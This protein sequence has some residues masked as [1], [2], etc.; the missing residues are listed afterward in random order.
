[1]KTRDRHGR[2]T[3]SQR[4]A[5]V[6]REVI[7]THV[8]TGLAVGSARLSR[9]ASLAVSP[10]TI[11][12]LMAE[13]EELGL[14]AQPHTSAGRIPTDRAYRLYV[15]EL[16]P[17]PRV[18]AARARDIRDEL[19]R[20]QREAADLLTIAP[21]LLSRFSR[22]A[23]LV[24]A[25]DPR[26][27]IVERF[28]FVRQDE[29]RVLAILIGRAGL[30]EHRV[31]EIDDGSTQ[32]ELDRSA[33][34]LSQEFGGH[35]LRRIRAAVL[36]RLA[37]ERAAYDRL[38]ARSLEL[39]RRT[40]EAEGHAGEVI[41]DGTSNLLDSP[42]FADLARARALLRA[43]E[44][45]ERLIVLLERL[46]E[47]NEVQVVIGEENPMAALAGCSLVTAVYSAAGR[48]MGTIGIV[49]PTRMDYT[50]AIALVSC[51]SESISQLLSANRS[52]PE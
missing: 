2:I 7:R 43:L 10:A 45:K 24:L 42:E 34:L 52:D 50:R 39:G 33:R 28:E 9:R 17:P 18:G 40:V 1:M 8:A 11:R 27:M 25:P 49:G 23:A 38:L 21:R 36:R 22:Q 3:L 35:S 16:M 37:E 15:D 14:L 26:R 12:H 47:S 44:E 13:L 46:M 5:E 19:T 30:V 32:D 41:V 48:P 31:L 20:G 29:R 51:L 4:H 6:L